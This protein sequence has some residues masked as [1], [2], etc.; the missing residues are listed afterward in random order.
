MGAVLTHEK[1]NSRPVVLVDGYR[2]YMVSKHKTEAN[3]RRQLQRMD[4]KGKLRRVGDWWMI[5]QGLPAQFQVKR[6]ML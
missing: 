2:Y 4:Y 6:R 3:A 5:L 1:Y